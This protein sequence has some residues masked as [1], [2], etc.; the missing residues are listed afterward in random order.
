MH[1]PVALHRW[2]AIQPVW[3]KKKSLKKQVS[4][5]N[6]GTL[7]SGVIARIGQTAYKQ[8]LRKNP[9]IITEKTGP[10]PDSNGFL[11]AILCN[12]KYGSLKKPY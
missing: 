12:E 2:Q 9:F 5:F 1:A 4:P 7:L 6:M 11:D 8:I 3:A 10:K